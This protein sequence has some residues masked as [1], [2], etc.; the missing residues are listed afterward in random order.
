MF[1][2]RSILIVDDEESVRDILSEFLSDEGIWFMKLMM[3]LKR[4]KLLKSIAPILS[5][6]I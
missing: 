1:A 3:D 4:L 5:C 2:Q 6:S